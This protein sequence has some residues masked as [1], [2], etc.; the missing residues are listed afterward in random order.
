MQRRRFLQLSASAM[1]SG[2]CTPAL[3]LPPFRWE[4][5]SAERGH[6]LRQ[7]PQ[8]VQ[9]SPTHQESVDTLIIGGGVAGLAAAWELSRHGARQ[10]QTSNTPH[11]FLLLEV[12][13]E[14]GGNSRC[15]QN[16]ISAYPLAAHY[17]PLP[18]PEAIYVRQLLAELGVLR[19]DPTA[20][21]PEYDERYLCA[22]PQDRLFHLGRWEDGLWPRLGVNAEERRQQ[23][24]FLAK[25]HQLQ[26]QHGRD[27]KRVFA[28]PMALSST[29]PSWRALDQIDFATWL[30]QAGFTAPSVHWLANYACRDDYGT[31]H[32]RTSA[33]AGLHYFAC[34]TG[35]AAGLGQNQH[36]M[37]LTAPQGNGWLAQG[38]A[39][40]SR[41]RQRTGQLVYRL[42]QL[43]QEQHGSK[44]WQ[45]LVYDL[46]KQT[47][48]TI[49]AI[50]II[51]SAPLFVLP[52]VWAATPPAVR[53]N[54]ARREY[55]PWL[56]A[57]LTLKQFPAAHSGAPLAW[58]NVLYDG[59]GLGYVV[60]THQRFAYSTQG[61]VLTYYRTFTD[62]VTEARRWLLNASA[63]DLYTEVIADL[64]KAHP[65][66]PEL[67]T[68]V[69]F[70]RYGHAMNCPLPNSLWHSPHPLPSRVGNLFFA[71]A[72]QS[73]FSLFEEAQYRGVM[74]AQAVKEK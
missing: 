44:N 71:H 37:V 52:K 46:K 53:Q 38:L 15:G 55:A 62:D 22:A 69:S 6:L 10:G 66:L 20:L 24:A 61:T 64:S 28:L 13:D 17:L 25:M 41:E 58:D 54:I 36:D 65:D 70:S 40:S 19:G 30:Q 2:A 4:G 51:W 8:S 3:R 47:S 59:L 35:Q 60:A 33:W 73:G 45:V 27:G 5:A 9:S 57:N 63:A 43:P 56:V 16:A 29:D 74:A 18:P 1:L 67:V 32:H 21:A 48:Y 50:N 34:R 72:D 7:L 14:I 42:T 11:D 49:K 23:T 12:E 31:A 68:E 26:Q 39:R